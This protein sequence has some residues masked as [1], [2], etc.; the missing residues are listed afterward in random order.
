MKDRR[1][2]RGTEGVSSS[3]IFLTFFHYVKPK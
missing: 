1:V 2:D 3:S